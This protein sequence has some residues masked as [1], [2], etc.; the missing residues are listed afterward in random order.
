M[1]HCVNSQSDFFNSEATARYLFNFPSF[2]FDVKSV[3]NL[4]PDRAIYRLYPL[5]CS[6]KIA[7][8]IIII[9]SF[10][11]TQQSSDKFSPSSRL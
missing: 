9:K 11:N 3:L 10:T 1:I 6:G 5:S 4:R 7:G 8:R 2:L